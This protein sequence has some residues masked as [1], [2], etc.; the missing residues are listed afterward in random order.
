MPCYNTGDLADHLTLRRWVKQL[1]HQQLTLE[2][3]PDLLLLID[4]DADD[5]FWVGLDVPVLSGRFS[6]ISGLKGLVEDVAG[7]D[8]VEFTTPGRYLE[9]HSPL[10]SISFGQ[11]TADGSFDGLSSWTEKWSNHAL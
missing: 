7:L 1:R 10:R 6:T 2:N 11:D 4:M 3:A 5:E 9:N 8:Y